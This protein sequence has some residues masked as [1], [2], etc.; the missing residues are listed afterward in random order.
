MAVKIVI[1]NRKRNLKKKELQIHLYVRVT[2]LDRQISCAFTS[3][4]ITAKNYV[5]R[6]FFM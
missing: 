6:K 5:R 4:F 3:T 2:N 1:A